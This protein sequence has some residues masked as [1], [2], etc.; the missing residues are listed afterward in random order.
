MYL[1]LIVIGKNEITIENHKG[2]LSFNEDEIKVNTNI[3]AIFIKGNGFEILYIAIP[4][5]IISGKF[6]SI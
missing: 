1:K 2:I 5:I 3:G 4:T 6:N